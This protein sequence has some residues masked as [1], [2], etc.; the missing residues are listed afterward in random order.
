MKS[1]RTILSSAL[2]FSVFGFLFLFG[3]SLSGAESSK[4]FEGTAT[5]TEK[6]GGVATQF[7]YLR[8]SDQ[9][10]IEKTDKSKP[11]PINIID[12]ASKKLTI[13]YPHNSS[14]VQVDLT[15]EGEQA[16]AA[17]LP[18]G[19]PVPPPIPSAGTNPGVAPSFSPPP[20]FPTT[21][22]MPSMP[23]MPNNPAAGMPNN[24]MAGGI[25][26]MPMM[27]PPM[28]VMGRLG[29]EAELKKSDK[30]KKIQ[31][32]ECAL[33]TISD[34]KEKMEI[35]AMPDAELF[36]FRLLQMNYHSRHFGPQLLEERWP[37]LL[38]KRSLFPLEVH[39]RMEGN[40][41]ERFSFQADK[42]EKKKIDD[43]QEFFKPPENYIEVDH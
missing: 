11:E 28:P 37:G 19:F 15:K 14:F 31:G 16:G 6:R 42:I 26:S 7:L 23:P 21:P 10:R 20:G 36:P 13:V 30:T 32:Y 27:M 34:R 5:F 1:Q 22:P 17:N 35:W 4:V 12:L 39:L 18:T 38:Q 8:K 40:E 29:P 25:P 43:S 9:L 3:G 2:L 41:E 24:P 33:Y